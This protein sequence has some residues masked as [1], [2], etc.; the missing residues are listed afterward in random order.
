MNAI[1]T[2]R[3]FDHIRAALYAQPWLILPEWLDTLCGIVEAHMAG[4]TLDFQAKAQPAKDDDELPF[5]YVDGVAIIP[6]QG[7]IFPK[8]NLMTRLSGA[9]ALSDVME[10]LEIAIA[11]DP[12]KIIFDID[13][14]GGSAQGIADAAERIRMASITEH[15]QILALCNGVTASAAYLLASQCEAVF[16]ISG[17]MIGSIGVVT[18]LEN[19]D[20]AERNEGNDPI[21]IRSSELKGIGAGGPIT[22]SQIQDMQRL[23]LGLFSMFKANVQMG[24]PG[25][26]IEAVSTG[27]MWFA[28][29][30]N[31]DSSAMDMGLIDGISTMEQMISGSPAKTAAY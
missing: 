19:S 2:K 6:I 8:A 25:I 22:P 29:S 14:P 28:T 16:A 11:L 15:C 4:Q 7:P 26:D 1:Q 9:T 10:N 24:R 31:E 13:S 30:H 18:R 23:T 27:Q 20:R 5:D 3:H 17:S 21:V 12:K